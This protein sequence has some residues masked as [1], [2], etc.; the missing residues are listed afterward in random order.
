MQE[1]EKALNITVDIFC[2]FVKQHSNVAQLITMYENNFTRLYFFPYIY[3][4]VYM[5]VCAYVFI[6]THTSLLLP[7]S[8][9]LSFLFNLSY[10]TV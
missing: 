7:E 4:C 10:L 9:L 3:W 6:Y 8:V 1:K 5:Y 2:R